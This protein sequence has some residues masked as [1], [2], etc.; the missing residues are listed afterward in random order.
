MKKKLLLALFIMIGAIAL[1][2]GCASKPKQNA[3]ATFEMM[4]GQKFVIELLPEYAPNTVYNF[5]SLAESGYYEGTVIH[6][7]MPGVMIQ[8]GGI[9]AD[10]SVPEGYAGKE[11]GYTIKGEFAQN[12]FE[13][14]TL[15]HE[16]GV[17]STARTNEPDSAS[18][19][20]FIMQGEYPMWDG[21]YA[22][23]GKVISGI[24][25]IDNIVDFISKNGFEGEVPTVKSVTIE[26]FGVKY[27]KPEIIE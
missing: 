26:T 22:G 23:F 20:F 10:P 1:Q 7:F 13:K 3:Q 12:G 18:G 17:I 4:D 8:G 19:Q 24:E 6:R 11:T 5:I 16:R 21:A 27:P 15:K 9:V 14:N 25:V 2:T